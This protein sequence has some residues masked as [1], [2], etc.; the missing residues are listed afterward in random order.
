MPLTLTNCLISRSCED[1]HEYRVLHLQELQQ[2]ERG[3][4]T[5][6]ARISFK[7]AKRIVCPGDR[8]NFIYNGDPHTSANWQLTCEA[9][10]IKQYPTFRDLLL[11]EGIDRCMPG[12]VDLKRAIKMC[13]TQQQ[14]ASSRL[15]EKERGVIAIHLKPISALRK[16]DASS[17]A[18]ELQ[19]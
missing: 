1:E 3:E 5:I 11:A 15:W 13:H 6:A 17:E 14:N 16:V 10:A 18:K 2:I 4:K 9:I 12:G 7:V 8:L 19:S